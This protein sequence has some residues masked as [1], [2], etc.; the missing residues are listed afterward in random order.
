MPGR[1]EEFAHLGAQ[2]VWLDAP[3]AA[4][5]LAQAIK[6]DNRTRYG[7]N[8]DTVR[9]IEHIDVEATG[10][11]YAVLKSDDWKALEVSAGPALRLLFV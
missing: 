11:V 2:V 10:W 5:A 1:P 4:A 6:Y 8:E 9:D 3:A 7:L